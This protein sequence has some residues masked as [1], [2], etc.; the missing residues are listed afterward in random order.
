MLGDDANPEAMAREVGP[1]VGERVR[2]L[3]VE[4]IVKVYI[5]YHRLLVL[6][7]EVRI[8]NV[9][10][11]L[12]KLPVHNIYTVVGR[13]RQLQ[14]LIQQEEGQAQHHRQDQ[15][16]HLPGGQLRELLPDPTLLVVSPVLEVNVEPIVIIAW[17]GSSVLFSLIQ[18][19]LD[20]FE[21]LE[22]PDQ[23]DDANNAYQPCAYPGRLCPRQLA[24][25]I[26][27]RFTDPIENE[28]EVQ[29]KTGSGD[30]VEPK[31][32]SH[33]VV[34]LSNHREEDIQT[35]N[36]NADQGASIEIVVC[37]LVSEPL[38]QIVTDQCVNG[39]ERGEHHHA[40][41]VHNSQSRPFPH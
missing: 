37:G 9:S 24:H 30:E 4:P 29:H 11:V 40:R 2:T 6:V 38:P 32:K 31:K 35:E 25:V 18:R 12:S 26:F 17:A 28:S 20:G 16:N 23:S 13:Q 7:F 15:E 34:V 22:N 39:E 41:A 27:T 33:E 36:N 19:V 21:Q 3:T 14:H 5:S 10:E 8:S 1:T